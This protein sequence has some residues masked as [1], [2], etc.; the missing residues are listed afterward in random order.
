MHKIRD[1][2]SKT[3]PDFDLHQNL[4][5]RWYKV[6]CSA[7][8]L[9]SSSGT[10]DEHSSATSQ[11]RQA[12]GKNTQA[13]MRPVLDNQIQAASLYTRHLRFNDPSLSSAPYTKILCQFTRPLV[14][15]HSCHLLK[16]GS[17]SRILLETGGWVPSAHKVLLIWDSCLAPISSAQSLHK[18]QPEGGTVSFPVTKKDGAGVEE[19]N[20]MED[21]TETCHSRSER[22]HGHKGDKRMVRSSLVLFCK[23][24][25]LLHFFEGLV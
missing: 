15:L 10:V 9:R 18:L 21:S 5:W 14:S 19:S 25:S 1:I 6:Q 13:G 2:N 20:A 4:Y 8:H 7:L 17:Q 23:E 3:P 11:G 24:D 22:M 16:L 12:G